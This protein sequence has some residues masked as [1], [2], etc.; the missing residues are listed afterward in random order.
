MG[1][2][3][4]LRV[5]WSPATRSIRVRVPASAILFVF[6]FLFLFLNKNTFSL[7]Q[8]PS[9]APNHFATSCFI[10]DIRTH[11]VSSTAFHVHSEGA[12]QKVILIVLQKGEEMK[13]RIK[14][15]NVWKRVSLSNVHHWW[16]ENAMTIRW[17]RMVKKCTSSHWLKTMETMRINAKPMERCDAPWWIPLES[18]S[19]WLDES[20]DEME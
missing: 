20:D 4:G 3:G 13:M 11:Q 14:D 17:C 1:S 10:T 8:I 18:G 16:W 12:K 5:E 19:S 15:E 7:R 2:T 9:T 6:L